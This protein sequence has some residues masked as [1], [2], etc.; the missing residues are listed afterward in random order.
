M[1]D[2]WFNKAKNQKFI[3]VTTLINP[4]KSNMA[5]NIMFKFLKD[6]SK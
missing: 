5:K 2:N 4:T 1:E 6:Q 3:E